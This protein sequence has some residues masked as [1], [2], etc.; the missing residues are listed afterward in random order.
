[1]ALNKAY[2]ESD[3]SSAGDEVITPFYAV[4]PLLKYLPKEK[5]IWCPFDCDWSAFVQT[6]KE[7]GYN[8]VSSHLEDGKD[9]FSY[10]PEQWDIIVSNPPFSKKDR[11]L[12]R[13]YSF[14]KPFC[15]LLPI[16]SLQGQ[17]RYKSFENGIEIL[18][19]DKRI[20]YHTRGNFKT[21][22]KGN[23]FASGYFCHNILPEK[24]ILE[25]LKK[26]EREIK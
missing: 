18:V 12:E 11:V 14:N 23:H 5:I 6:F 13:C 24:L 7:N 15:L 25:N 16:N 3:R 26:Y 4:E 1:M 17:K 10:E 8:V 21:Y 22:T 19:F 20:D 2:L 9:F